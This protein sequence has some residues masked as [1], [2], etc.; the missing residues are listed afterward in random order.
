MQVTHLGQYWSVAKREV[1]LLVSTDV[2]LDRAGGLRGVAH[3]CTEAIPLSHHRRRFRRAEGAGSWEQL[4]W[5][6]ST[7]PFPAT[8]L[9]EYLDGSGRSLPD[10]AREVFTAPGSALRELSLSTLDCPPSP[11]SDH[12]VAP[13]IPRRALAFGVTYLNSALERETEGRRRDYGYVYRAVKERGERP[14]IFLK[15]TSPEHFVGPNG[16]MGL[17]RDRVNSV[18]IDGTPCK[19]QVASCGIEPE[20]AAIVDSAGRIQGYT[21]ADDVSG[22]RLENETLLYLFQAKFFTGGLVLGPLILISD[23]QDNPGLEITTRI[24]SRGG[25]ALFERTSNTSR[26]NAP[27][28]SLI[29]WARSHAMLTPGEVFSTGTDVVPDGSVKVLEEG[30]TVEI[31]CPEIGRLRH[32]AAFVPED[33][34]L[35]L[36]YSRLEFE[37]GRRDDL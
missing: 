33:G 31:S 34:D 28:H 17:R 10:W 1:R 25:E 18:T 19:R 13:V 12:L 6:Y 5:T 4:S 16:R 36:D 27:L 29:A 11:D 3:D 22:N 8:E 14:E 35:N 15:G 24:F 9:L 2:Q 32:G 26:I 21:L 20:L 37:Q 7:L 23:E 30:M